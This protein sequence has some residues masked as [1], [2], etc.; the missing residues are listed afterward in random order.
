MD[1]VP[2][3]LD[4]GGGEV[5]DTTLPFVSALL[6]FLPPVLCAA[7]GLESD[8]SLREGK[9]GKATFMLSFTDAAC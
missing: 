2:L 1:G 5:L 6:T 8:V 4:A 9:G 3:L 7:G